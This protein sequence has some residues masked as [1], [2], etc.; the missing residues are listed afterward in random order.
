MTRIT[1]LIYSLSLSLIG[2]KTLG[3]VPDLLTPEGKEKSMDGTKII[4]KVV[5]AGNSNAVSFATVALLMAADSSVTDG[6]VADVD[7]VFTISNV[8]SGSYMLRVTNMGYQTLVVDKVSVAP[9]SGLIDVGTLVLTTEATKLNEVVVRAEKTMIINDIDKKIVNV[10]QDMLA[11][12]TNV[13]ELLEK[14]P[15]VSLDENGNPQVRGKGNVIVLIDG[16]PSSMYGSDLPTILKSFPADLIDRIDVMTTPSAKYEGDGASGVIDIITKKTK[17][18]GVNG[19]VRL[20]LGN[21]ENYNTGGN[22]SFKRGKLGIN[23]SA[24]AAIRN[25]YWKRE[26]DRENFLSDQTTLYSQYGTGKNYD[27]DL[28]GR[29]GI[30]Y[31]LT[32]KATVSAGFNYSRNRFINTSF[33]ENRTTSQAD[34]LME[35]FSRSSDQ[36]GLG[37]NTNMYVDYR[38]KFRKEDHLLTFT[39]SYTK[40]GSDSDTDFDQEGNLVDLMVRQQNEKLNNRNSVY[41]NTDYTWPLT[42]KATVEVG[43]RTRFNTN[44]NTNNFLKYDF[45]TEGFEFDPSISNVFAYSDALYT[46]Y[47]TFSQKTDNWGVRVGVRVTDYNQTI[48]Q[49]NIDQSFDVHFLTLVPSLAVTRK[50]SDAAQIKL[51]Y[52]RRVQRPNATWLNPFTDISDPLNIS[53]GNPNLKPEFTHKAELGY[54]NYEENSGIGPSLFMDYS[55]NAITRIKTIDDEGISTSRYDNVGRELA[56]GY[57]MDFFQRLG[58]AIKINA[59]GRVFRSEVVSALAQIDNRIWSYSGNIN[60]YIKLPLDFRASAY[61]NYEGPRAIAQGKRE[62]IVVA[63]MGI[64]K[65]MLERKAT[66]SFSVQDIFLSRAY[67]SQL[68]TASYVQN[69]LYQQTNRQ[70]NLSF[71]YRFGKISASRDDA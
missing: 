31:D 12:S 6:A 66:I 52:S 51:N 25:R 57:E 26:I 22:I 61:V 20:T 42:P 29:I 13:S 45:E 8:T 47:S 64:R 9:E 1:R 18:Q 58:E 16:K 3:E 44:D 68:A 30:N 36:K 34:S 19:G 62:G 33:S 27:G 28:F 67:K 2:F 53:T 15:A 63:N 23:A 7:G 43:L 48:N 5:E 10:G 39:A 56:Y 21:R 37:D 24:N 32:E 35:R 70:I 38:Q 11:T 46:G 4:G 50:L 55:N 49:V 65:S 59:S 54:S 69:S 71:Q 40:G 17:I 60:A 41:L 14:V